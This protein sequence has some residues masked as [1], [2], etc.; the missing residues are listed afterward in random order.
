MT[1]DEVIDW[2]MKTT[3]PDEQV[4]PLV[5]RDVFA[6]DLVARHADLMRSAGVRGD[7]IAA[8]RACAAM[9]AVSPHKI[10]D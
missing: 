1:R 4:Y 5:G 3:Q 6:A 9:M 7:K 10:P 2:L 8:A